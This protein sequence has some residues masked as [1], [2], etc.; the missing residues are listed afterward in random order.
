[1]SDTLTLLNLTAVCGAGW[2]KKK[3]TSIVRIKTMI[4]N[5]VCISAY[6][7]TREQFYMF[8]VYGF[9]IVD[10]RQRNRLFTLFHDVIY[11]EIRLVF[12]SVSESPPP[13]Y[14]LITDRLRP[15]GERIIFSIVDKNLSFLAAVR[16]VV[17]VPPRDE[18]IF[19][20]R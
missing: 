3:P 6:M 1:M 14:C 11:I 5:V 7:C 16:K 8:L 17:L 19:L 2:K 13:P 12:F 9:A 15:E 4:I 18:R 20:Y 10:A